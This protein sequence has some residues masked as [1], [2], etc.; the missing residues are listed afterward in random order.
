MTIKDFCLF[1]SIFTPN[2]SLYDAVIKLKLNMVPRR[3][4]KISFIPSKKVAQDSPLITLPITDFDPPRIYLQ[5]LRVNN[6]SK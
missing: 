2:L 5:Y 3:L 1:Q 6:I 4:E